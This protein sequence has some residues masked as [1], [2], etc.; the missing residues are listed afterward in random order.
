[1]ELIIRA[2]WSMTLCLSYVGIQTSRRQLLNHLVIAVISAPKKKNE[3][4]TQGTQPNPECLWTQPGGGHGPYKASFVAW[5]PCCHDK[6]SKVR[7][8]H[9]GPQWSMRNQT[10]LSTIN[11]KTGQNRQSILV[12]EKEAM[13]FIP[14]REIQNSEPYYCSGFWH[15]PDFSPGAK[16]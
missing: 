13:Q 4:S 16:K 2:T 5:S 9:F 3:E 6:F 7:D 15:F 1:M 12:S 10:Y 11:Q 8:L 14:L